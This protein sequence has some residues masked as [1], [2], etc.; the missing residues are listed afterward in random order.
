MAPRFVQ[1]TRVNVFDR[2]LGGVVALR[3]SPRVVQVSIHAPRGVTCIGALV[4]RHEQ[5]SNRWQRERAIIMLLKCTTHIISTQHY[6]LGIIKK[7]SLL[8]LNLQNHNHS[9][10]QC[11]YLIAQLNVVF[12]TLIILYLRQSSPPTR[13][14]WLTSTGPLLCT[15]PTWLDF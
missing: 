13:V 5:G 10:L 1:R 12:S 7:N 11:F 6:L 8:S 14:L 15:W 3:F 9:L 2:P 4:W